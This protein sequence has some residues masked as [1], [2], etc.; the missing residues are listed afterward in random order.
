MTSLTALAKVYGL[1][2]EWFLRDLD[3]PESDSGKWGSV[4]RMRQLESSET[5]TWELKRNPVLR[6]NISASVGGL[7]MDFIGVAQ[8]AC[9][10]EEGHRDFD[11]RVVGMVPFP[12][13][14]FA[15]KGLDPDRCS[16]VRV[17]GTCADEWFRPGS[18]VLV[19]RSIRELSNGE[20]F[21]IKSAD[22]VVVRQV[23]ME[24]VWTV[25]NGTSSW[26][27]VTGDDMVI[28]I[29]RWVGNWLS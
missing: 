21:L 19:D 18:V 14:V 8:V 1:P 25:S 13:N 24:Q 15:E 12:G 2:V 28:G 4:D 22:G 9:I 27:A 26:R 16:V 7:S 5:A 6:G 29:I 3:E 10:A 11:D 20:W 23:R 17:G